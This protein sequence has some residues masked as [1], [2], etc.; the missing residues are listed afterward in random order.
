L[1]HDLAVIPANA[2]FVVMAAKAGIQALNGIAR[3]MRDL[4]I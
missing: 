4:D 3:F 1:I 2:L